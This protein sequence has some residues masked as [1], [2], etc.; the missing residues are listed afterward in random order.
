M[1]ECGE[2]KREKGRKA[3]E[4]DREVKNLMLEFRLGSKRERN[5]TKEVK[6]SDLGYRRKGIVVC[7][8][9]V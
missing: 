9:K 6:K 1:R 4:R 7:H 8:S 2:V 3:G 5:C